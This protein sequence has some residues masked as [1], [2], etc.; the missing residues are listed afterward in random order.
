MRMYSIKNLVEQKFSLS[1]FRAE[2]GCRHGSGFRADDRARM[3]FHK[4]ISEIS[5]ESGFRPDD[6]ELFYIGDFE[7]LTA[8]VSQSEMCPMSLEVGHA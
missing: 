6:F 4:A 8:G 3:I 7:P 1:D 2:F 5:A